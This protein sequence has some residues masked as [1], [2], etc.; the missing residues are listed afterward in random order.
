MATTV[1]EPKECHSCDQN[2]AAFNRDLEVFGILSDHV[3]RLRAPSS[4]QNTDEL[5]DGVA[6][7]SEI[8][9]V[10]SAIDSCPEC[11][12]VRVA[13]EYLRLALNPLLR[14]LVGYLSQGAVL[15]VLDVTKLEDGLNLIDEPPPFSKEYKFEGASKNGCRMFALRVRHIAN[16][17]LDKFASSHRE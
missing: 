16:D 14:T 13:G 17:V 8:P 10:G 1:S 5:P 15:D 3:D 4:G 6:S 11:G 7:V 2:C 9:E 12:N